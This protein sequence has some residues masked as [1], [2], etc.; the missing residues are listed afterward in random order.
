MFSELLADGQQVDRFDADSGAKAR[1]YIANGIMRGH[2]SHNA[3][4][5]RSQKDSTCRIESTKDKTEAR[6]CHIVRNVDSGT[7]GDR[8]LPTDWDT[9]IASLGDSGWLT[10]T[11]L[12]HY[13]QALTLRSQ[14]TGSACKR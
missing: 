10:D 2:V 4:A 5:A 3:G 13:F 6:S 7:Q 14:F 1:M 8:V 11:V 12:D 9:A